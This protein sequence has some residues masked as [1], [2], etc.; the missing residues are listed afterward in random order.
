MNVD[1]E[2]E[3]KYG[4]AV[5]FLT[6]L[7]FIT[8]FI[9]TFL[10]LKKYYKWFKRLQNLNNQYKVILFFECPLLK[11]IKE[12][13]TITKSIKI[14]HFFFQEFKIID[15]LKMN[16]R[17]QIHIWI[18]HVAEILYLSKNWKKVFSPNYCILK[19]FVAI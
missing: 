15:N 19:N 6:P 4:Y 17:K 7:I 2:N 11:S 16:G 14:Q 3:M 8:F 9:F 13:R 12:W 18:V 5:R 10:I 1:L